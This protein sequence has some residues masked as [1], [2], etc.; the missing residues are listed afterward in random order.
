MTQ[1]GQ[2]LGTPAYMAPEQIEEKQPDAR[3]D[4]YSLG[5]VAYFLLSGQP[6][7]ERETSLELYAAHIDEPAPRL[8]DR[9]P[10]LP[11]DLESVIMRCL[12]KTPATRFQDVAELAAV[13]AD[14]TC[15]GQWSSS[16]AKSWWHTH[17]MQSLAERGE[18][19][20]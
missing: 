3:S 2:I 4:I 15:G 8:C 1:T 17:A 13:L 6:P 10:G 20:S 18:P 16:Q 12:A 5:G 9:V 14:T 7:F 19:T 11:A